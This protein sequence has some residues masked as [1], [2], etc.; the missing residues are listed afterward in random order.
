MIPKLISQSRTTEV[1]TTSDN[2]QMAY[3]KGSFETDTY[4]I[5]IFG[6]LQTDSSHLTTAINRSKAESNLDKKDLARD[7][8]VKALNYLLVGFSH[9]PDAAL[10]LSSENLFAIFSKYGLKMTQTS[11][12]TE[13]SL[14]DSMLE[15]F[16]APELQADI[17][18]LSGCAE[19]ISDSS[20]APQ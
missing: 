4:M 7:E 1:N 14:I 2:I 19:T 5:N 15:D 18:A 3:K 12:A 13:S 10:K 17:A 8:K 16:A 20:F 9:H 11:Y 6:E